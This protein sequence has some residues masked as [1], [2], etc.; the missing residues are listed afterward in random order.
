MPHKCTSC[1]EV[2]PD[3]TEEVL[4]GCPECNGNTFQYLPGDTV[5]QPPASA[6]D[7]Q[8]IAGQHDEPVTVEPND[9]GILIPEHPSEPSTTGSVDESAT[10]SIEESATGSTV[11]ETVDHVTTTLRD[12]V[13]TD[14]GNDS[15]SPERSPDEHGTDAEVIVGDSVEDNAQSN[16][17]SALVSRDELPDEVARF[18]SNDHGSGGKMM[19]GELT[20][21]ESQEDAAG[22]SRPVAPTEPARPENGSHPPASTTQSGVTEPPKPDLEEIRAKLNEQFEGI[23]VVEPGRYELNIRKL[24]E[25]EE[26]IIALKEDGRYVIDVPKSWWGE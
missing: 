2:F 26:T 25:R 14:G 1:H 20:V 16:A 7:D 5:E 21:G 13:S 24:F 3:G 22:E 4:R 8:S 6:S 10:E 15:Q 19:G 18:V 23:R 9:D 12:F 17:R 11:S